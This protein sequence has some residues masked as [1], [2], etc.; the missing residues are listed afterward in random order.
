MT[1][2]SVDKPE[3][4]AR[5]EIDRSLLRRVARGDRDAF[6]ALYFN[7]Q[8]RL[9]RFLLR[10]SSHY[11]VSEEIIND[12]MF[13]VWRQAGE[14]Q[15]RSKVSTWIMSIAFRQA[16]NM[17]RKVD[18]AKRRD[19]KAA[20]T[21]ALDANLSSDIDRHTRSEWIEAAMQRLPVEQ[22]AALE[23][24]YMFGHSVTE[25]AE[26]C[27][28]PENTVK[29]RMFAARKA[30]RIHLPELAGDDRDDGAPGDG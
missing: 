7:Y 16:T 19:Q 1:L 30:L 28:C 4:L 29:S 6:D 11:P 9:S 24:S 17:L 18:R 12:T 14:F 22:R 23:L 8:R 27:D 20:E 25:I 15:G 10:F 2:K 26:I 5:D 13:C 3:L 21:E